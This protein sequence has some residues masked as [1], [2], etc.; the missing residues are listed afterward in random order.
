[1][2]VA[3]DR[4]LSMPAEIEACIEIHSNASVNAR[5]VSPALLSV[6]AS[7]GGC[8]LAARYA[9]PTPSVTHSAC[10]GSSHFEL[11]F[12]LEKDALRF[13]MFSCIIS[14]CAYL[15]SIASCSMFFSSLYPV[16]DTPRAPSP[17]DA[18]L[19][20]SHIFAID[21]TSAVFVLTGFF[22][23]YTFANVPAH[24]RGDM[25][26]MFAI[27]ILLDVWL[28]GLITLVVGSMFHLLRRSFETRDVALTAIES[29]FS[30][31]AFEIEQDSLHWH[32]L[33]PSAWPVLCLFWATL[34]TPLTLAGNERLR[35][36][37]RGAGVVIP[38]INASAPIF[39]ISL[40]SLVHDNSNIFYI[41]ATHIGYRMLEF[42]LGIC[43]HS[44]MICCPACFWKIAGVVSNLCAYVL[45]AFVALWWAQL[46]S[47]VQQDKGT[48]IRM[49]N[50]SP[51]IKMHHGFLMRGCF[52]GG[53]LVCS[54][55]SSS[56][57]TLARMCACL[58]PAHPHALTASMAAVLLTWPVCYV[59]HLI[60]EANF[61]FQ[62]VGENAALLTLVV[63]NIAFAVALLW[64]TS[65]KAKAFLFVESLV[66]SAI[67]T[68]R[69]GA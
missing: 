19:L 8:A 69:A 28:A 22:A 7:P 15:Y 64:D 48:C 47:P 40:F 38:W 49:Y 58:A 9:E 65:W 6:V 2:A 32:S 10:S 46:G 25:C 52:L 57:N 66:D 36:C 39:I 35:L 37:H 16:T 24:D 45:A 18:F 21:M 62:L 3:A 43:L 42:N 29:A 63:P 54:V 60:L 17:V 67:S 51:C 33:N 34:L 23:A 53:T 55:V 30:L 26:K 61:G 14:Y 5:C 11:A 4:D 44:S 41:N 31:R 12:Q 50:F 59:V 20:S 56:E 13:K 1:M 27:Y 68:E